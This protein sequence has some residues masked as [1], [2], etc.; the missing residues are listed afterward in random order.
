[1][2]DDLGHG[3]AWGLDLA[4]GGGRGEV[5][6]PGAPAVPVTFTEV[7]GGGALWHDWGLGPVT[8]SAG[9]R[10]GFIC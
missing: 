3:L 1:M 6:L 8:L 10:V 7:A 4:F 5:A 2:R 9:G